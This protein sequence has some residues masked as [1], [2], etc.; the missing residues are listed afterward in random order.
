MAELRKRKFFYGYTVVAA[1]F[2]ISGLI[3]GTYRA[4]GLFFTP[5]SREFGWSSELTSSA[6]S[7]TYFMQ[8]LLAIVT[9]RLTDRL[10]PKVVLIT[11]G[12]LLGVGYFLMSQVTSIW[13]L[14]LFFGLLVGAG[15]SGVDAPLMTTVARWFKKRRGTLTGITKTG[16]GIGMLVIPIAAAQLISGFGWRNSYVIISIVSLVGIV[17]AAWF[18]KRDPSETGEQPDGVAQVAA[19]TTSA[20]QTHQF[21]VGE[22][23][24]TRQFWTFSVAFFLLNFCMQIVMLH[25]APHVI[26]LG[27][28]PTM[29]ATILGTV[30]GASILGRIGMGGISDRLGYKATCVIAMAVLIAGLVWIQFA[31]EAWMFFVFTALYGIAHGALWTLISPLLAELF[32]LRSLGATF[33]VVLFIST[34]GG[35]IGPIVSGRIFDIT[36]SYQ[37]GF[38]IT[39]LFSTIALIL[40][41]TLKP[42]TAK[43]VAPAALGKV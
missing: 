15:N 5:I 19:A 23:V 43:A 26:N 22:A 36:N 9:G 25:T 27:I 29:A 12:V 34:I 8:G 24:R 17:V 21:S 13:Q 37:I 31:R 35:A 30:G 20:F 33:G 18:L 32:G 28:S 1:G 7:L 3:L 40:T 4:Y 14:Y 38:L 10:G 2:I 39:L 11:C 41:A 16:A 6:Y 42:T